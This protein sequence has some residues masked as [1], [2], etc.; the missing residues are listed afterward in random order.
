MT[1][2]I[3]ITDEPMVLQELDTRHRH[4]HTRNY[5]GQFRRI[6]SRMY[7]EVL[8]YNVTMTPQTPCQH[9]NKFDCSDT[10]GNNIAKGAINDDYVLSINYRYSDILL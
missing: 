6:T 8:L 5:L 3:T 9:K 4:P 2:K 7:F 1:I 10:N